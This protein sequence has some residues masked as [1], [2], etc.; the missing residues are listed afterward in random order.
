[1]MSAGGQR[2]RERENV[3]KHLLCLDSPL[4]FV[5]V[6]VFCVQDKRSEFN[7]SESQWFMTRHVCGTII[8]F[9][10]LKLIC[11]SKPNKKL[12]LVMLRF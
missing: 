6:Y 3:C 8:L 7:G 4:S 5:S 10:S 2:E 1:M 11:F 9:I 12:W